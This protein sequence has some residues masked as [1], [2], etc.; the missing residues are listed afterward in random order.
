MNAENK[1][2]ADHLPPPSMMSKVVEG[3]WT[4]GVVWIVGHALTLGVAALMAHL[5]AD[6]DTPLIP[7]W[8][9]ATPSDV[10]AGSVFD[11]I[12]LF[13]VFAM[14]L[15][16]LYSAQR[17]P[18][19]RL[20]LL[21]SLTVVRGAWVW[22]FFE[23]KLDGPH[24]A[25]LAAQ[26]LPFVLGLD[27]MRVTN[28]TDILGLPRGTAVR[29]PGWRDAR[30]CVLLRLRST[31]EFTHLAL[32]SAAVLAC[33]H[34][35]IVSGVLVAHRVAGYDYGGRIEN[36]P[37]FIPDILFMPLLF[38]L[39]V[40]PLLLAPALYRRTRAKPEN[41][42]TALFMLVGAACV[43]SLPMSFMSVGAV[44]ETFSSAPDAG[45]GVGVAIGVFTFV[46]APVVAGFGA[47]IGF[48]AARLR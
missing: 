29:E 10:I 17:S 26:M 3:L 47:L 12:T 9:G 38:L 36:V 4:A 44:D 40:W 16:L 23:L 24:L 35:L 14:F 33:A 31:S 25:I 27:R 28:N 30:Q 19:W 11:A 13:L 15:P 46:L 22:F 48:I 45:Q 37:P 8:R 41:S 7:Y 39:P 18:R 32:I 43:L 1:S 6:R 42:R 21:A 20:P 2:R 5:S 34:S